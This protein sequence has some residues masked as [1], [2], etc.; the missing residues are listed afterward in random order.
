[1]SA[2]PAQLEA[3]WHDV[4]CGAY[5]RRPARLGGARLRGGRAGAR[6]R[7]R[8]RAASRCTSPPPGSRSSRSTASRRCSTSSR[9]RA[10]ARGLDVETVAG[11]RAS[12]SSST[13]RLAFARDPR[14]DAARPPARRARPARAA[15]LAGRRGASAPRRRVRRRHPRRRC[16]SRSPS[17][18]DLPLLPDVRELDGWVYSSQPLGIRGGRGRDRGP[19]A[20]PDRLPRRRA[21][22]RAPRRSAST[23]STADGFEAR[24]RGRRARARSSG[25]RSPPPT[26]TSARRSAS[27]RPADGTAAARALSRADEHLRRPR[28]HPLP[29]APLRVA[30]DRLLATPAPG[31]AEGFDPAP[32]T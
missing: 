17:Q 8:H 29:A 26:T 20:A 1:M 14:A 25:S 27:W 7:R 30:R 2:S 32:T 11:R 6:A 12:G 21:H 5:A 24:G 18:P 16:R 3:I 15:L 31:P 22:R 23:S 10:G 28:Q 13:G 4:E 9:E 19:P